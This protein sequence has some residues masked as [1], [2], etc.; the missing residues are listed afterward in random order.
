VSDVTT[1]GEGNT[2]AFTAELEARGLKALGV[3]KIQEG[4][5]DFRPIIQKIRDSGADCVYWG[6][7]ATEG[8]M[9]KQQ[10]NEANLNALFFGISGNA[11]VDFLKISAPAAEGAF[12][13]KPGIVLS[14]TEAG[15][16]FT[17][18]YNAAGYSEP[19]GAYTPYAYEA[20]LILFN[21]LR[22]CGDDPTP[23]KMRDA[24]INSE[25]TGIMGTTVFN[26]IGQTTNVAAYLQVAQDGK[27]VV[28]DDSEYRSGTRKFPGK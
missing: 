1:Y 26:E 28:Y 4:T 16:K 15:R 8:S 14:S 21:A 18:Q 3:E 2:E 10:M 23:L 7:V 6:G 22:A 25:T 11:T 13:V 20:A 27:W 5:V 17:E 24:I 19:I 9:L 12:I